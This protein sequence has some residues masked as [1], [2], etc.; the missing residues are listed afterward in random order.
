[1]SGAVHG[2]YFLEEMNRYPGPNK[3]SLSAGKQLFQDSINL[4]NAKLPALPSVDV[5]TH[6]NSTYLMMNSALPYKEVSLNL[7]M[8]DANY[9]HCPTSE[10]WDEIQTM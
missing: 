6:W 10:E 8:S 4:T 1:V 7:S 5:P 3:Q 9:T 2:I